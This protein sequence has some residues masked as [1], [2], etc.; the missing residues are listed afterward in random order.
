M[1][2]IKNVFVYKREKTSDDYSAMRW[3]CPEGFHI[4][5]VSERNATYDIL[6]WLWISLGLW[7]AQMT[8]LKVPA[9]WAYYYW[10]DSLSWRNKAWQIRCCDAT[11]NYWTIIYWLF[12][13]GT[14]TGSKNY[15]AAIRPRKDVPTIPDNTWTTI[16]DWSS[17]ASWAWIFW[18]ESQQIISLSADG[19]NWITIADRNVWATQAWTAET[20]ACVWKVFQRWNN[21][22]F[23]YNWDSAPTF[24]SRTSTKVD[25][26]GYWPSEYSSSAYYDWWSNQDWSSVVNNDLRWWVTWVVPSG[27][28]LVEKQ[29]YP[30]RLPIDYQEVEYIQSTGTQWIDTWVT[31]TSGTMSQFKFMPKWWTWWVALWYYVWNDNNDWRFFTWYWSTSA[32]YTQNPWRPLFDFNN[33]RLEWT[34]NTFVLDTIYELEMWN[35]YLKHLNWANILTWSQISSFTWTSTI[36]L[37]YSYTVSTNASNRWYYVKIYESWN[38][39]RDFIPCYRKSDWVIW[40]YDLV[41]KQF[42]TNQWSWTFTKW[43]NV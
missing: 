42:Y 12:S 28:V 30:G 38:L 26:S 17:I 27:Y 15:I 29:V 11:A 40:L 8:Y 36:K 37:D 16:F 41:E 10:W 1:P 32:I 43:P 35:Y 24:P 18:K 31:P 9:T 14:S 2:K 34:N 39:V 3:P 22:W 13:R 23:T 19:V 33:S 7:G 25:T 21:Y 20:S 4:P 6:V 5:L